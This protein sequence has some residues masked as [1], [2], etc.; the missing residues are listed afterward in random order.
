MT[1]VCVCVCRFDEQERYPLHTKLVG[2]RPR[3]PF[4]ATA[5]VTVTN[6]SPAPHRRGLRASKPIPKNRSTHNDM[7]T[8]NEINFATTKVA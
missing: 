8:Q 1:K 7:P 4:A 5:V 2:F 6:A 3:G